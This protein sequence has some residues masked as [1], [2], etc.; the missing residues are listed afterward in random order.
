MPQ[1]DTLWAGRSSQRPRRP[2]GRL[3]TG[4]HLLGMRTGVD[5]CKDMR[6]DAA[7]I[8][9]VGHTAGEAAAASAVRA[10]QDVV[11]IAQERKAKAIGGGKGVIGCHRVKAGTQNMDIAGQKSVVERV[12]PTAFRRSTAGTGFGIKP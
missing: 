6:D 2:S 7:C 1:S 3:H 10:A 11:G 9:N 4:Q 12:E 8:N 5:P